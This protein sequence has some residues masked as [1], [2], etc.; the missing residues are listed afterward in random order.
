MSKLN[1]GLIVFYY[2][3]AKMGLKTIFLPLINTQLPKTPFPPK[4]EPEE[5][6]QHSRLKQVLVLR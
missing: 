1:A 2:L 3:A 6:T 4:T 5:Q